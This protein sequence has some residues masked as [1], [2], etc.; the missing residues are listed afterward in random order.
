M[1]ELLLDMEKK[2]DRKQNDLIHELRKDFMRI[3]EGLDNA[4]LRQEMLDLFTK[5]IKELE[6]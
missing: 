3:I 2:L 1:L 6:A 4:G 5:K